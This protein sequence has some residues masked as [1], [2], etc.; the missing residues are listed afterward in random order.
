MITTLFNLKE[1]HLIEPVIMQSTLIKRENTERPIIIELGM[2][3]LVRQN[4]YL[5]EKKSI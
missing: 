1:E 2:N 5:L 4:M 3:I